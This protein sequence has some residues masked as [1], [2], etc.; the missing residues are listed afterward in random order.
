M[1]P[2]IRVTTAA[3]IEPVATYDILDEYV[4][5]GSNSVRISQ[6]APLVPGS[7]V[8]VTRKA[9]NAWFQD[10][11]MDNLTQSCGSTPLC[12]QCNNCCG[13]CTPSDESWDVDAPGTFDLVSERY[14]TRF[15]QADG[16]SGSKAFFDQPLMNAIESKYGPH[17][18]EIFSGGFSDRVRDVGIYNLKGV[19]Q[20]GAPKCDRGTLRCTGSG[21]PTGCDDQDRVICSSGNPYCFD[22]DGDGIDEAGGQ[23]PPCEAQ[24]TPYC[25]RSKTMI[26]IGRAEDIW[27]KEVIASGFSYSVVDLTKSSR[28]VTVEDAQ[29][30]NPKGP[31]EG[32]WRYPFTNGGQANL[33]INSFAELGRHD[34]VPGAHSAGPNAYV[35]SRA[36]SSHNDSGPHHRWASGA[37]FDNVSLTNPSTA[38]EAGSDRGEIRVRNRETSG[39]GHGWTGSSMVTWNSTA[40]KYAYYSPPT[41]QNWLLGSV[42]TFTSP[43]GTLS[44]PS[45]PDD[46]YPRNSKGE[47][48]PHFDF[49]SAAEHGARNN[50]DS[51]YEIAAFHQNPHPSIR[52]EERHYFLGDPDNFGDDSDG[53]YNDLI[54]VNPAWVTWLGTQPPTI[55]ATRGFD[56]IDDHKSIPFTIRFDL[57]PNE[58]VVHAWVSIRAKR[59][60]AYTQDDHHLIQIGGSGATN[61]DFSD[62]V[63]YRYSCTAS[64]CQPVVRPEM[65]GTFPW[66][67]GSTPV[68]RVLD[69]GPHLGL[70][71]QT[72]TTPSGRRYG[73]LNLNFHR[74]TRIDW[75]S[76][77]IVVRGPGT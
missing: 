47:A 19:A 46:P 28:Q 9:T 71:N 67:F 57:A 72:R 26:N 76:L 62:S 60:G 15:E 74:R 56:S 22:E 63:T 39:T 77:T 7:R 34:F 11:G 8:R 30:L 59:V 51:L 48:L 29:Y 18:L 10:I 32:G 45:D 4:P 49:E 73:E 24:E 21:T 33:V 44:L 52:I 35:R 43:S 65:A 2:L 20:Q 66:M 37:L 50:P 69:L 16:V 40:V 61:S 6:S 23:I 70:L 53:D 25:P 5:S 31:I 27:V 41:G 54:F 55:T 3:T 17:T 75:A 64:P 14:V 13:C 38:G 36:V 58:L 68:V 1:G 42:G 12:S